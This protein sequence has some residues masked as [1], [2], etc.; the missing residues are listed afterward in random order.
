MVGQIAIC[1]AISIVVYINA[2]GREE[3]FSAA[4]VYGELCEQCTRVLEYLNHNTRRE[5]G[6]R[7][8]GE[9]GL[10]VETS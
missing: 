6:R 5:E 2:G 9:G 10:T 3:Y 8:G 7:G 4:F 1:N